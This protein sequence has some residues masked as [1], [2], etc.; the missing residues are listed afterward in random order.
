MH[1]YP[2]LKAARLGSGE[3]RPRPVGIKGGGEATGAC[4]EEFCTPLATYVSGDLQIS[5]AAD[6]RSSERAIQRE[7][8]WE[9][10]A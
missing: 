6:E 4:A 5:R 7:G 1:Y 9:S 8:T 2:H 3:V 10:D